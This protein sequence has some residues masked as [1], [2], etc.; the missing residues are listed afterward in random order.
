MVGP[1]GRSRTDGG[2][3]LLADD[4][5]ALDDGG[6]RVVDAVKHRLICRVSWMPG[7]QSERYTPLVGSSWL[8]WL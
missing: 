7:S 2:V 6:A 3:S 8:V 4:H 5:G 1:T